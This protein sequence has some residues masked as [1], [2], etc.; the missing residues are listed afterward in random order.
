MYTHT[1]KQLYQYLRASSEWKHIS[2]STL[3]RFIKANDDFGVEKHGQTYFNC[4]II[5][6]RLWRHKGVSCVL[7]GHVSRESG[8]IRCNTCE[9]MVQSAEKGELLALKTGLKLLRKNIKEN[10]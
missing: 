5:T 4:D 10:A 8:W 2:N 7:C 3:R 6:T 9:S 1:T